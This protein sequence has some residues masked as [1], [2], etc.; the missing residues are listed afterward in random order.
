M[1]LSARI[2]DISS[3]GLRVE[4]GSALRP[5]AECDVAIP[6]AGQELRLRARVLR[7]RALAG[8][9]TQTGSLVF[10]AGLEF[11]NLTVEAERAIE[12]AYGSGVATP[13][14]KSTV[15]EGGPIKIKVSV[16]DI[17]RRRHE[18]GE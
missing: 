17:T 7:C 1:T 8:S 14:R 3:G 18:Q 6:V 2:L 16:A 12:S 10:R 5:S 11:V 13:E 9:P 15:R 4:V